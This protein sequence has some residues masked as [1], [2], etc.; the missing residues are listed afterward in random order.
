VRTWA[1]VCDFS[2]KGR[3]HGGSPPASRVWAHSGP[4]LGSGPPAK[5]GG[6]LGLDQ[7]IEAGAGAGARRKTTAAGIR[8]GRPAFFL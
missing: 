6:A 3:G 4:G 1:R 7:M 2:G 8:A 5:Q